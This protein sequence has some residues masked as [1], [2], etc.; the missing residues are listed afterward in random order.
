MGEAN[1]P[2]SS[3]DLDHALR[4]MLRRSPNPPEEGD[5]GCEGEGN[6]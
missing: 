3:A 6:G 4:E 2:R 1:L 5:D